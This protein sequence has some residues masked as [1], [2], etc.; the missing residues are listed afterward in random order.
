MGEVYRAHDPRLSRDVALKI[1][2]RSPPTPSIV[3][4]FSREARAA[5]S[6]NHPNI[7]AVYDVGIEAGMPY[8]VTEL[9]EGE[10]LRARLDRGLLP[11]R[12]AVDYGIQIAQALDAAHAQGHLASRRQAGQR[13][14]HRRRTGEAARFRHRQAERT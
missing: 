12:K 5:G 4:R 13:V 9:L 3:A 7:V 8:V 6:L 10:T 1:L 14:H 11:F 2:R